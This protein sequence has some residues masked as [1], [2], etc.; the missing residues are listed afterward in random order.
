MA[1][2]LNVID[3]QVGST[4]TA[5]ASPTI[6]PQDLLSQRPIRLGRKSFSALLGN[7]SIHG[8]APAP[9]TKTRIPWIS[10][11]Q[12]GAIEQIGSGFKRRCQGYRCRVDRA[13][14]SGAVG[15]ARNVHSAVLPLGTRSPGG[16]VRSLRGHR[17]R[18]T[19]GLCVLHAEHGQRRSF[20]LRLPARQPTSIS[21]SA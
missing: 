2:C 16:L 11:S 9:P 8:V 13:K 4:P 20:P 1:P 6:T 18:E 12:G 3:L 19:E 14:S 15:G 21:G 5:L 7:S 10:E 17:G